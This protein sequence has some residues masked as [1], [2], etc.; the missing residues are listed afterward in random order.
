MFRVR[1]ARSKTLIPGKPS[2][3]N[4]GFMWKRRLKQNLSEVGAKLRMRTSQ[5]DDL[6]YIENRACILNNRL[7]YKFPLPPRV[8]DV[9]VNNDG[10]YNGIGAMYWADG[11]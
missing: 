8:M 10:R 6:R 7:H 9:C 3:L 4:R 11:E 5:R 1:S 2:A